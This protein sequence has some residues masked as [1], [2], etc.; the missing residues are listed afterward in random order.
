[1]SATVA[2]HVPVAMVD[3]SDEQF[4]EESRLIAESFLHFLTE[5]GKQ[6]LMFERSPDGEANTEVASN[7]TKQLNDN[8]L[9]V[10][11]STYS[12]QW[13]CGLMVDLLV[14]L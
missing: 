14:T 1:M 11:L 13:R 4:L 10:R 2:G 5:D 12:W 3:T 6:K 7:G 8:A 9:V